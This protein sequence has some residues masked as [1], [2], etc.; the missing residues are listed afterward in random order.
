MC[1]FLSPNFMEKYH[2]HID[3][4]KEDNLTLDFS[5]IFWFEFQE[6]NLIILSCGTKFLVRGETWP[7]SIKVKW[8]VPNSLMNKNHKNDTQHQ[9]PV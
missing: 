7:L 5:K 2:E 9:L 6:K 3:I 4:K 8:S 1:F